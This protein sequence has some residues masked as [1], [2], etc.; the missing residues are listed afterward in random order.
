MKYSLNTSVLLSSVNESSSRNVERGEMCS[1]PPHCGIHDLQK[2]LSLAHYEKY[3]LYRKLESSQRI[4]LTTAA[5]CHVLFVLSVVTVVNK[6]PA[7]YCKQ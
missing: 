2:Q 5:G 1:M 7:C 6:I 4:Q 3:I